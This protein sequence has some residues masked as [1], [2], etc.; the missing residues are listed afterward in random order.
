MAQC[1]AYADGWTQAGHN[2]NVVN[3]LIL[4]LIS[5]CPAQLVVS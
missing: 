4:N 1:N 2:D 5:E 3:H